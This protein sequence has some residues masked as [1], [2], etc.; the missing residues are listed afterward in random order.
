[1]NQNDCLIIDTLYSNKSINTTAEKLYLTQPA[2]TRRIQKI[3]EEFDTTIV[4]R[5]SKGITFTSEG[6]LIAQHAKK[7][8][9]DYAAIQAKLNRM[10]N[11]VFGTVRIGISN[12]L[13]CYM[14]P[15]LLYSYKKIHPLVDFE[16]VTGYSSEV[17]RLVYNRDVQIG[18][19][20]GDHM[21]SLNK[22]LIGIDQ[23]YIVSKTPVTLS[24]IP[25]IPR[26]DFYA[27]IP[28]QTMIENWWYEHFAET[29]YIAM[30]LKSG[31]TCIE[32]IKRGLGYGIFLTDNFFKDI[33]DNI[34]YQPLYYKNGN[35]VT[36]NN[37]M[38]HRDESDDENHVRSF[39]LFCLDY[40]EG[41]GMFG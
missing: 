33:Q 10:K 11:D 25:K 29:P 36:R 20:R 5:S 32:M 1:M 12:S 15:D 28:A 27:D 9:D 4:K 24:E 2:L 41:P 3:E 19:V 37:W 13:A 22:H 14:L 38:I 7:M 31:Q 21:A 39:R 35:P 34:S 40:F 30:R 26:I 18:F 6:K 17:V 16:V 8:L 23:A